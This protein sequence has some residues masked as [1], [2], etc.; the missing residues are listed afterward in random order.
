M[1]EE[2]PSATLTQV[3]NLHPSDARRLSVLC[4]PVDQNIRHVEDRLEI[5]IIRKSHKFTITGEEKQVQRGQALLTHL[6]SL[7]EKVDVLDEAT[8]HTYLQDAGLNTMVEENGAPQKKAETDQTVI[9]TNRKVIMARGAHQIQFVNN[10][11]TADVNF[12]VGPAGTGKTYLA[13]ACAVESLKNKEVSRVLLV[14]PAVEVGEKLGFLPGDLNQ[15]VD[16]YLRPLYDALYEMIGVDQFKTLVERGTIEAAPLAYMRGRTLN[17]A[18]IILDESQNTTIAQMKMFLTRIGFGSKVAI[19]GDPTQI[20]L[21]YQSTGQISGLKHVLG[22][23]PK[24][25]GLSVTY[26]D[27]GDVV[28]HRLVQKIVDAYERD[29]LRKKSASRA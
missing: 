9:K 1:S 26:F 23:L 10:I 18:F 8:L 28:R 20:D 25:K 19:T 16:P 17:D 21:P 6:Y 7:V 12:G 5:E 27:S 14:R 13:V 24:L 22:I 4:G 3:L 29:D 11:R 2:P 15:K